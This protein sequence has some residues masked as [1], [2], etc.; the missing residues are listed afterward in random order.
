MLGWEPLRWKRDCIKR[1]RVAVSERTTFRR[2]CE[3]GWFATRKPRGWVLR[4]VITSSG[5]TICLISFD[6][7]S[8]SW[9]VSNEPVSARV[10][11]S[12]WTIK[13]LSLGTLGFCCGGSEGYFS[14][15]LHL[16]RFP[17]TSRHGP[18]DAMGWKRPFL[19]WTILPFCESSKNF[20]RAVNA[21]HCP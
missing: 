16:R 9:R 6:S 2:R 7:S 13:L 3:L 21:S 1:S 12:P 14:A 11:G 10:S 18:S 17:S 20:T 15:E 8:I 5:G 4:M 19:E